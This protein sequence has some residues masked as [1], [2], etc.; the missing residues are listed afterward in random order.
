MEHDILELTGDGHLRFVLADGR[1]LTANAAVARMLD[2]AAGPQDLV[3]RM[4]SEVCA[5]PLAEYADALRQQQD[6]LCHFLGL[7]RTCRQ[8]EKKV[9][10]DARRVEDSAAGQVAEAVVRDISALVLH[11]SLLDIER[12]R[13]LVML[14]SIGEGVTATDLEGN[15]MWLNPAAERLS[16]WPLAEARGRP[17]TEVF[18]LVDAKTRQVMPNPVPRIL[19]SGERTRSSGW[20]LLLTRD[21]RELP[22]ADSGASIR[23]AAGHMQGAVL[24]FRDDSERRE[25]HRALRESVQVFRA[26]FMRAG[27]GMVLTDIRGTMLDTNQALRDALGYSASELYGRPLSAITHPDDIAKEMA[28]LH[29]AFMGKQR[30]YR[31]QMVKRYLR[32]DGTVMWGSLTASVIFDDEGHPLF[33]IGMVEDITKERL[34]DMALEAEKERLLVTLRSI[35]DGVIATDAEGRIQLLNRAAEKLTG[36]IQGEAVG[37]PLDEVFLL[38]D[39]ETRQPLG[40]DVLGSLI[41]TGAFAAFPEYTLLQTREGNARQIAE[42]ATPIHERSGKILGIVITFRDVTQ[43]RQREEE[44]IRGQKLESL[45]ILAGG[46]AH[47]FNN[48]LAAIL[49]N[50][51]FARSLIHAEETELNELLDE[52]EKASQRAKDLTQ[53]LL[54]FAKGGAPMKQVVNLAQVL[55][56]ATRFALRGSSCAYELLLTPDMWPVEVDAAQISQVLHNLMLNAVQ[57]MPDGGQIEVRTANVNVTVQPEVPLKPGRYVQVSVTDH[58]RG[59]PESALPK[60]FDPYFTTKS[61]GSGMGLTTTYSIIR[62]H[63]GYISA[64]SKVGEG[65]TFTFYL[66]ATDTQPVA[67]TPSQPQLMVADAH[68]RLL[69]MDDEPSIRQMARRVLEKAGYAVEVAAD[70]AGAVRIYQEALVRGEAFSAVILDITVPGGMGGRETL[71]QLR[72]INPT[73]KA[74]VSSGYS[75]DAVMAAHREFGFAGVVNKPYL[76][77]ELLAVVRK[78]LTE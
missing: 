13:S 75:T 11:P 30:D 9:M 4:L 36:W 21:G 8:R 32:K 2:W 22:V 23:D 49:G 10:V 64:S 69:V 45:G 46:I 50:I 39:T 17:L 14:Q 3:G 43:E 34:A 7:W 65:T 18:R 70:G 33:G 31:L 35:G 5:C 78:V 66:P 76:S 62:K 57:A 42:S 41:R 19:Q 72:A 71:V 20:G 56:E 28:E 52:A 59:I 12:Q 51:S 63:N 47:D 38:L 15:V 73:V 55:Q 29:Q 27:I 1:I 67:E 60:I 16:G 74:I 37:R 25:A 6:G 53:Q 68:Q 58:G 54:T 24:V 40:V 61:G 48:I 44:V 26:I 77:Q